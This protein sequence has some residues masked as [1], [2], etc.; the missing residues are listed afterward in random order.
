MVF[1]K[2]GPCGCRQ[3]CQRPMKLSFGLDYAHKNR[4]GPNQT[5]KDFLT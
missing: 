2:V 4:T 5:K 1:M 3:S